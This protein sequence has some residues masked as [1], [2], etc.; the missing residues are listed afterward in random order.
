MEINK[1][2]FLLVCFLMLNLVSCQT[3]KIIT[4]EKYENLESE[5]KAEVDEY[6]TDAKK[7]IPKKESEIILMFQYNCFFDKSLELNNGY[8]TKFPK[9]P[10]KNHYGQ[11]FATFEKKFGNI[12]I[13]LS[14]GKKFS[15]NQKDGYDYIGVCYYEKE[16]KLYIEY[17]NFPHMLVLE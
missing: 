3:Q 4:F 6:F 9:I 15:I 12:K 2:I 8:K 17:F 5:K 10:N 7:L 11:R 1:K 16:N 13:K 14:D